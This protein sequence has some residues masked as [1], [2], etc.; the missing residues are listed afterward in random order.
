MDS[1]FS[2]DK[3][4]YPAFTFPLTHPDHLA[5]MGVMNGLEP[6]DS[7]ACRVLELGC[8]SG[9]NLLSFAYALPGSQ[10][11]G[12]DLSER[13][14]T[15]AQKGV[16]ELGLSNIEFFRQDLVEY[17]F[18]KFG[19][20]DLVIAHGVFSWVPDVVRDK[21]LEICKK[22]LNRNGI[23]YISYNVY[24]GC[25][26]RE[27]VEEAMRYHAEGIPDL[28]EKADD[29][30]RFLEFMEKGSLAGSLYHSI[31]EHEQELM[32]KKSRATVIHDEL[33]TN[34]KPYYFHE[35]ASLL[36]RNG[37][38]F[39]CE[40]DPSKSMSATVAEPARE[41]ITNLKND[42]IRHEQYI[43]FLLGRRFR[44]SL[45]CSAA[46]KINRSLSPEAVMRHFQISSKA[47]HEP[48][49]GNGKENHGYRYV[50]QKGSVDVV[51][52]M[53][54]AVLEYLGA[55]GPKAVSF[56]KV[57]LAIGGGVGRESEVRA[58]AENLIDLFRAGFVQFFLNPTP[59]A[60]SVANR[61][62]ASD[63]AR[64]Q[65]LSGGKQVTTLLGED[66]SVSNEFLAKLIVAADGTRDRT[67]LGREMIKRVKVEKDQKASF[68][69]VL[70]AMLDGAL[71][72]LA[73]VGLLLPER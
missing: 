12:I 59:Y 1:E 9:A 49:T 33:S 19:S 11:V 42:I 64:W 30:F 63:F 73:E 10:F 14:I 2:Y 3:V 4:A 67:A 55:Q 46:I 56:E 66:F 51:H 65:L 22:S 8:G 70:P 72:K 36:S 45:V 17:D 13:H 5:V 57:I 60:A 31:I 37:L 53:T 23:G 34:S 43:D 71:M 21:V 18:E 54:K 32:L 41:T 7:G 44:R 28:N 61:P 50:G 48:G 62:H 38:Q 26:L 58:T 15:D 25:H 20:F 40:S 47:K 68:K 35:F 39:M 27:I 52:P 29:A 16:A 69:Q 24:P 6:I